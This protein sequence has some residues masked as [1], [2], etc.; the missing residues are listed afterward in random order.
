[1][2]LISKLFNFT[3]GRQTT[4]ENQQV[5]VLNLKLS[6]QDET[7]W[8]NF[9]VCE[10]RDSMAIAGKAKIISWQKE[11]CNSIFLNMF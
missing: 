1:M 11:V 3:R 10:I 7:L 2:T 9:Q 4:I 8:T 5:V 6:T